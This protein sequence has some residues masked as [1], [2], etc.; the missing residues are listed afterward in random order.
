MLSASTNEQLLKEFV[1]QVEDDLDRIEASL[2]AIPG[3]ILFTSRTRI[4]IPVNA[5]NF[6]YSEPINRD[7]CSIG[8]YV[9]PG[10]PSRDIPLF[11]TRQYEFDLSANGIASKI[12]RNSLTGILSEINVIWVN[13]GAKL[14]LLG[15]NDHNTEFNV[16]EIQYDGI[17]DMIVSVS[18]HTADDV[19]KSE[20]K[21]L[22]EKGRCPHYSSEC[23]MYKLIVANTL[24]TLQYYIVY[25]TAIESITL[26]EFE[27]ANNENYLILDVK[28]TQICVEE[29]VAHSRLLMGASDGNIYELIVEDYVYSWYSNILSPDV[30][31]KCRY[32]YEKKLVWKLLHIWDL[33]YLYNK[34]MFSGIDRGYFRIGIK[35][36]CIYAV[37][38]NAIMNI[39]SLTKEGVK[40]VKMGWSLS[41]LPGVESKGLEVVDMVTSQDYRYVSIVFT[42]GS[43]GYIHVDNVSSRIEYYNRKPHDSKMAAYAAHIDECNEF[44]IFTCSN[45]GVIAIVRD[46]QWCQK[47]PLITE[48]M[49]C[50]KY[51]K[52]EYVNILSVGSANEPVI[53]IKTIKRS[54]YQ[55]EIFLLSPTRVYSLYHEHPVTTLSRMIMKP[56]TAIDGFSKQYGCTIFYSMCLLL[57]DYAE[58]PSNIALAAKVDLFMSDTV[59]QDAA[60]VD[61]VEPIFYGFKNVLSF[62]LYEI[63]NKSVL[64]RTV[65]RVGAA[66]VTVKL[67]VQLLKAKSLQ[68]YHVIHSLTTIFENLF[69]NNNHI[70]NIVENDVNNRVKKYKTR[71]LLHRLHAIFSFLSTVDN[72]KFNSVMEATA[73]AF[74]ENM[75]PVQVGERDIK[76]RDLLCDASVIRDIRASLVYILGNM[77][78]DQEV[79]A[80]RNIEELGALN[81]VYFTAVDKESSYF[82]RKL[83]DAAIREEEQ[84]TNRYRCAE[85]WSNADEDITWIV[86]YCKDL[87]VAKNLS[88]HFIIDMYLL[89]CRRVGRKQEDAMKRK[90]VYVE[91]L[92]FILSL[93]NGVIGGLTYVLTRSLD[94]SNAADKLLIDVLFE[95]LYESV[96][97]RENILVQLKHA[98]L[99]E[100]IKQCI[101]S[102][103]TDEN[104]TLLWRYYTR[105][106]MYVEAATH[107]HITAANTKHVSDAIRYFNNAYASVQMRFAEFKD[108]HEELLHAI[109]DDRQCAI[110]QKFNGNFESFQNC[111]ELFE[112][113]VK[114]AWDPTK[115][116]EDHAQQLMA[117]DEEMEERKYFNLHPKAIAIAVLCSLPLQAQAYQLRNVC[118]EMVLETISAEIGGNNLDAWRNIIREVRNE[119]SALALLRGLRFIGEKLYDLED[120]PVTPDPSIKAYV[121]NRLKEA[122]SKPL[123]YILEVLV[124]KCYE[125]Y[126]EVSND[127]GLSNQLCYFVTGCAKLHLKVELIEV[128]KS[129]DRLWDSSG[130]QSDG[131]KYFIK[132]SAVFVLD[133][134]HR[135]NS[136][137]FRSEYRLVR[138]W[139]DKFI[140]KATIF[141]RPTSAIVAA[142]RNVGRK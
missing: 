45:G 114:E 43:R 113:L 102:C 54:K 50:D 52:G 44:A 83:S 85:S 48:E 18:L 60:I 87:A 81:T 49:S 23:S 132:K 14:Y 137:S 71:L 109:I 22:Q 58:N 57:C 97:G 94:P 15:Y 112:G 56:M 93:G 19:D 21:R 51:V 117:A 82:I 17:A 39:F 46:I 135:S 130:G 41:A 4:E 66:E 27:P 101:A 95:K 128:M 29:G 5:W 131:F 69:E 91:L 63:W 74:P 122:Y 138:L 68:C 9:V 115:K 141:D 25:N 75:S 92:D 76:L 139:L 100:K 126:E 121:R 140:T 35:N 90:A 105:N 134:W 1:A 38:R 107:M 84:K 120:H 125:V 70:K 129:L 127:E 64:T 55:K 13:V 11:I 72:D 116:W 108:E 123:D 24:E 110:Y 61:H 104:V 36:S 118:R 8:T 99:E 86:V 119:G 106:E 16:H 78:A 34:Y 47:C 65:S 73:T 67:Q 6:T 28:S 32:N 59:R 33:Q 136:E 62:F 12:P 42:N 10:G 111:D 142:L 53:Y 2:T 20:I 133:E 98:M 3:E 30:N 103:A 89:A 37:T 80:Y 124:V 96:N 26:S 88:N 77:Q 7:G 40:P 79:W 31:K